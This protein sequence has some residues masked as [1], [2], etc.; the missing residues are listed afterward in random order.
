MA[1]FNRVKSKKITALQLRSSRPYLALMSG[2]DFGSDSTAASARGKA[3]EFL[4]ARQG[5]AGLEGKGT[6]GSWLSCGVI[7]PRYWEFHTMYTLW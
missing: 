1:M 2:L 6:M 3:F 5:P 4:K 7:Y